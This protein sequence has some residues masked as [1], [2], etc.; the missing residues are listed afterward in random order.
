MKSIGRS[1]TLPKDISDIEDAKLVFME[2]A[3]DIGITARR[4][5]E[6]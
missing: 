5:E 4:H 6:R 2:L 1:T 3:D